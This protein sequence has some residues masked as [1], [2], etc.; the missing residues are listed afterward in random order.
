MKQKQST[1]PLTL[2]RV[3]NVHC[4]FPLPRAQQILKLKMQIVQAFPPKTSLEQFLVQLFL[5]I[6]PLSIRIT[7]IIH[8]SLAPPLFPPHPSLCC[9]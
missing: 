3:A 6:V 4:I 5:Y 2:F 1:V 8:K 9:V 7:F